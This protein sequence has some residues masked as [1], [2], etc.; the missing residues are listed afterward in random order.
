MLGHTNGGVWTGGAMRRRWMQRGKVGGGW[1]PGRAERVMSVR[2][3]QGRAVCVVD[4]EVRFWCYE[5]GAAVL[6]GSGSGSMRRVLA[7]E[8]AQGEPIRHVGGFTLRSLAS[9]YTSHTTAPAGNPAT[10]PYSVAPCR[11]VR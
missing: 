1:E 9:G 3:G 4:A 10:H 6:G 8:A 2:G 5:G 11:T 7:G